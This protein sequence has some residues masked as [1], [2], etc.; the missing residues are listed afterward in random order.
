MEI[1]PLFFSPSYVGGR[2][3][4]VLEERRLL[5]KSGGILI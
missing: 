5:I 1:Y 3:T 4:N 2:E